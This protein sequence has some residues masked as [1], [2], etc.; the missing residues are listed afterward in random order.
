MLRKLLQFFAGIAIT[1]L[2]VVTVVWFL[3]GRSAYS[4]AV[5]PTS[6][7]AP[8]SSSLPGAPAAASRLDV[9]ALV[10]RSLVK[11]LS[12]AHGGDLNDYT[13]ADLIFNLQDESLPWAIRRRVAWELAKRGTDEAFAALADLAGKAKP[14]L[15]ALIAEALGQCRH[16]GV[17]KALLAMLQDN[18]VAVAQGALRGLAA[19][20]DVK[21]L[22]QVL[23]DENAPGQLRAVAAIGL[24]GTQGPEAVAALKQAYADITD[25]GLREEILAGLGRQGTDAANDFLHQI[26]GNAAM[27]L[28][29]RVAAVEAL[30]NGTGASVEQLFRYAEDGDPRVRAAAAWGLS[31]ADPAGNSE[32]ELTTWLA[33]ETDSSV[34]SRIYQAM[35]NQPGSDVSAVLPAVLGEKNPQTRLAGM[36][37]WAATARSDGGATAQSFDAQAVPELWRIALSDA[38]QGERLNSVIALRRAATPG[39][40]GALQDIAVQA[41]NRQVVQAAQSALRR[42]DKPNK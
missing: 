29:L 39:A 7:P 6:K 19:K 31:M 36:T 42:P 38:D 27:P 13:V 37:W 28:E 18:D 5:S 24:G 8:I 14:P 21:T 17:E 35:A 10:G 1:G 11:H 20:G 4:S 12:D 25:L 22:L 3:R 2:V 26:A 15:K 33:R 16:P 34:R 40:L 41:N 23:Q 30:A 32:V 9:S